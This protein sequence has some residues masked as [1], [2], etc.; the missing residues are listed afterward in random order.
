[1][2]FEST[3]TLDELRQRY[4]E[5]S[6]VLHPDAGGNKAAFLALRSNYEMALELLAE[7]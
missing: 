4:K 1:M 3:P 2:G 6:L 5:L 7:D